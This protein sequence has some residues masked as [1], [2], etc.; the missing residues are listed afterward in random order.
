MLE[1]VAGDLV[2]VENDRIDLLQGF[3]GSLRGT[4]VEPHIL[5]DEPQAFHGLGLD[6]VLA[7]F[8]HGLKDDELIGGDT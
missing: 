1:Q 4:L 5:I 3:I 2:P 6:G 8:E 7:G